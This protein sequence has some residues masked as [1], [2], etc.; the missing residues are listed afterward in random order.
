MD[1]HR[2]RVV[3][4]DTIVSEEE[5]EKK[6]IAELEESKQEECKEIHSDDKKDKTNELG[7]DNNY[8]FENI[9]SSES[10]KK[11]SFFKNKSKSEIFRIPSKSKL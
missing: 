2:L 11:S 9:N 7:S 8:I 10:S 1:L 4:F 6:S 5:G 3:E